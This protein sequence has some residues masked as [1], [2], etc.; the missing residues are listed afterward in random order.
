MNNPVVILDRNIAA[1]I[2]VRGN[3]F[4]ILPSPSGAVTAAAPATFP[5]LDD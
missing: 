3:N 5:E 4:V 2:E 1:V